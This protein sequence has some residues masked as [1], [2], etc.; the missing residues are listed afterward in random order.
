MFHTFILVSLAVLALGPAPLG[1]CS[2]CGCGDPL[3]ALGSESPKAGSLSL[4]LET[5]YLTATA[6]SDENDT[7]SETLTQK[8]LNSLVTFSPAANLDLVAIVPLV[9]KDWA[10]SEGTSTD[11]AADNETATAAPFGLG[12]MT[13]GLRYFLVA[14][15]DGENRSLQNF[16]ISL[17]STLPTGRGE[18]VDS[19]GVRFDQHGQL[20]TGAWG[21]YL[22]LFYSRVFESWNLSAN[23]NGLFH[24]TNV[25]GYAFGS[26]FTWGLQAQLHLGGDAFA[27]SLAAE[28]RSAERDLSLQEPQLNTGGTVVALTPGFAFN[29]AGTFGIYGKVQLPVATD[30]YGTQTV[31]A[32]ALFGTQLTLN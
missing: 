20:G 1:A 13:L 12:D 7:Q 22:G 27:L 11:P 10:L 14:E 26:S 2:I 25:E 18:D 15:L 8:T 6:Q 19:N 23:V 17:G 4:G 29:P 31:G 24:G 9:K 32:T 21:P 5:V 3:Q 16:A 30:L 28:G